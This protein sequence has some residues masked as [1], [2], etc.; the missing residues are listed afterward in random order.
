MWRCA[1]K[2]S[3]ET[4]RQRSDKS[5]LPRRMTGYSPATRRVHDQ[6]SDRNNQ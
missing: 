4:E 6:A 3:A 2:E 5:D 1:G